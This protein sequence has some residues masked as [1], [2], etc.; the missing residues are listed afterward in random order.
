[1][2][3][4]PSLLLQHLD[5]LQLP[6]IKEHHV[7]WAQEAAQASR[8]HLDYL[9]RLIE[10]EFQQRHQR[11]IQRRVQAAHFPVIKTLDQFRWDWPKKIN[12]LQVQ[13]LFRLDFLANTATSSF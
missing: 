8:T 3:P 11:A 7:P 1:M 6:F 5:Y 13:N 9:T 2:N 4:V 10:G 12:R